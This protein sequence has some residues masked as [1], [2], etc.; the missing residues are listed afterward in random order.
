MSQSSAVPSAVGGGELSS[1]KTG[2]AKC[3]ERLSEMETREGEALGKDISP[4]LD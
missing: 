4:N 1:E 2:K 3:G